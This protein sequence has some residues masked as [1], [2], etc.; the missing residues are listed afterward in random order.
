M[1]ADYVFYL[2]GGR[3]VFKKGQ[4]KDRGQVDNACF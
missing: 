4:G 1:I 2:N 3:A